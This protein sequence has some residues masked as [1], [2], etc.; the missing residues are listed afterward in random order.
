[1]PALAMLPALAMMPALCAGDDPGN[2]PEGQLTAEEVIGRIKTNVTCDW[3][4][5]TVDT[6]KAGNPSARVTGI[7]CTFTATVDVLREAADRGCNL[8]I[9]HE[10]TYYNHFDTKELLENDPVYEAKQAIIDMHQMI[11]FRF[12]DHWHRTQP[13]GIYNGMIDKLQ[14]KPYLE[15]GTQNVFDLPQRTLKEVARHLEKVFPDANLRI[16]GD[17]ALVI[18]KAAFIAGAPGSESHI[19]MLQREEVNLVVIGEAREWET[20]EYVRDAIQAGLPKSIIILGHAESEEAGM[21][22]C[23]FWMRSFV[24]EVPIHFIP[25]GD[26]FNP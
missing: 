4:D 11:I 3:S 21:G 24:D 12:H 16:I 14:W 13:D 25:A 10:P 5:E 15:K 9:T 19:R 1:M 26:P 22:Y 6:F 20:V 17:P 8:V 2:G 18:N 7:A 23:A